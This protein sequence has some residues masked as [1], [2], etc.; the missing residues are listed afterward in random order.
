[1]TRAR[2]DIAQNA[3][4]ERATMAGNDT[5]KATSDQ[6]KTLDLQSFTETCTNVHTITLPPTGFEPVYAD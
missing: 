6:E 3:A 4:Q 1:M 5:R 2:P